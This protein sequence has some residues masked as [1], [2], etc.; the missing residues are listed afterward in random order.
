MWK[1]KF[2]DSFQLAGENV[3]VWIMKRAVEE[4]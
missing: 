2:R 3:I 4:L 1:Y